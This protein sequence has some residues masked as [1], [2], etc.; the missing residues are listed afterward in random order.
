MN[1]IIQKIKQAI[2]E[3][4]KTQSIPILIDLNVKLA[5]YLAYLVEIQ[6]A[7]HKGYNDAYALRKQEYANRV[8][9]GDGS[10]GDRQM[11]AEIEIKEFRETENRFDERYTELKN[12][13]FATSNFIDV[14]T[15][16]IA[17]LRKEQE[18]TRQN[19]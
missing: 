3:A 5:G 10:M 1:D 18:I 12:Y 19:T 16:K 7:A 14:L 17:Y 4:N 11:R 9:N 2:A 6:T 8:I 15:Q 13:S